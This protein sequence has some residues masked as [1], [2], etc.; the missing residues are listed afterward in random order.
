M[1][2]Y[3]N[4]D[5]D[6][7]TKCS[8][9]NKAIECGEFLDT[10]GLDEPSVEKFFNESEVENYETVIGLMYPE[11]SVHWTLYVDPITSLLLTML[12]LFTTLRV[13]KGKAWNT[14]SSY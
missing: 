4:C 3:N 14:K 9:H 10:H 8:F 2:F 6:D 11:I 1:Y 12:I 7:Y 5:S 13:L